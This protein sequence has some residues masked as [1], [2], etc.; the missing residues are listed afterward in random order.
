MATANTPIIRVYVNNDDATIV[1]KYPNPIKN[2]YGFAVY[3]KRKGETDAD[4]EP[5]TT[6]VGF[7][8]DPH[9]AYEYRPSTEWPIQKYMWIDYF[10]KNGDEVS[11]RVVPMIGGN[12]TTNGGAALTKASDL[13][14]PWTGMIKIGDNGGIEAYF[15]R[16]LVSSQFLSKRLNNIPKAERAKTLKANLQDPRSAIRTF[17]GGNLL[18]ALTNL[19]NEVA[20]D[21]TLQLYA[22]L[23][24]LD[25]FSLIAGLN[26]LAKRA[27][28]ILANGAFGSGKPD[29][30]AANA[31]K[32]TK[33]DLTRRKVGT[34]HFAHNKFIV[35]TQ[36]GTPIKVVTGSTNW[37]TNGVFTQINNAVVLHDP[38]VAKYYKDEWDAIKADC[39]KSG[40][41]LYGKPYLAHNAAAK[42]NGSQSI[43]TFFTPVPGKIDM[44]AAIKL[45]EG[46]KHGILFLMFKPGVEGKSL[47]LY[48]TI[49][50][51]AKN[52]NLLVNGVLN[53][54]PGGTKSPTIT[55]LS[56]NK[57]ED[58][59]LDAVLPAAINEDFQFWQDEV[60][61]QNVTIHSKAIVI[62]PFSAHPV[63][64]TGSHNMGDK[65]SKSNDDN[66]NIITGNKALTQ[67]YA[68]NM[69]G[70]YHHYRWRFYRSKKTSAPKWE[71]NV[72]SDAWQAWYSTGEKANEIKFWLG[73]A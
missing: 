24:E 40:K 4:A 35:I 36:N 2:C 60:A 49:M 73:D 64:I 1:W 33:V 11:Y 27:H 42:A 50:K 15:N 5:V 22:A 67:A 66:L 13:A 8:D 25:E 44:Q 10:V 41:G 9:T 51:M 32:L 48:D 56:H 20:N 21:P 58:G 30:Q 52:K 29:P 37:T 39:D 7:Q 14:T 69:M 31:K 63:L 53:A 18:Q 12:A 16:G 61:K 45:I 68:I 28:V 59:D 34:P 17:L 71:G 65:A 62:D 26:K 46:A 57:P 43:T 70:V 23:Y 19:L 47:M 6:T 38:E 3:R 55:F 72:K 54:D